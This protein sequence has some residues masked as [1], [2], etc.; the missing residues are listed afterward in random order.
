MSVKSVYILL[1]PGVGGA[2]QLPTAP[3]RQGH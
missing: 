2:T 1:F 3:L